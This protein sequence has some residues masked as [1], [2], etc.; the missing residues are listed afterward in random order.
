MPTDLFSSYC[1][2]VCSKVRWHPARRAIAAELRGHLED[3]AA[4]LLA[5]GLS[6]RQTEEAAVAA[7]G[8]PHA[9]G[10]ALDLAHPPLLS[11]GVLLTKVAAILLVPIVAFLLVVMLGSSVRNFCIGMA[12]S[13]AEH[14][15]RRAPLN[16]GMTIDNVTYRFTDAA[17]TSDGTLHLRVLAYSLPPASTSACLELEIDDGSGTL[18]TNY[19]SS[20]SNSF[21][22]VALM[23]YS[24]FPPD[25]AAVTLIYSAVGRE[26]SVVLPLEEV[27]AP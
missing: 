3:H 9:V 6:A 10:A 20:S 21:L 23:T 24:G 19:G 27:T 22:G 18:H 26:T 11:F 5:S 1:S 25:C 8:D 7:M 14:I 17:L 2:A 13:T 16:A 4:A 15:A 12:P